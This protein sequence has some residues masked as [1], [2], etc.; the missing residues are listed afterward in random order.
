MNFK[1][2]KNFLY[3]FLV[4]FLLFFFLF[5]YIKSSN[6]IQYI[7]YPFALILSND[8]IFII[9]QNGV[10]I[11]DST[12]SNLISDEIVFSETEK[13]TSKQSL[14]KVTISQF[15]N[16]YIISLINDKIYFFD[17]KGNFFFNSIN[18]VIDIYA[19][20]YYYTLVPIKFYK[21][22]FFYIIGYVVDGGLYFKYYKFHSINKQN[23]LINSY[24]INQEGDTYTY[25]IREYGLS[26]EFMSYNFNDKY[27]SCFL[28]KTTEPNTLFIYNY[29]VNETDIQYIGQSNSGINVSNI[30]C[31]KSVINY[32]GSKSFICF[33]D[34]QKTCYCFK[35]DIND[36]EDQGSKITLK[37]LFQNQCNIEY[38]SMKVGYIQG[39]EE[40][41]ISSLS[42]DNQLFTC[43]YNESL[44]LTLN[45]NKFINCSNIGGYSI[46]YSYKTN[47][48][49]DL[50]DV[51]CYGKRYPFN[52]LNKEIETTN[53]EISTNPTTIIETIETTIQ[54]NPIT[55]I[56]T[57]Y[58]I[59]TTVPIL[60]SK[61]SIIEN[62]ESTSIET[63]TKIMKMKKMNVMN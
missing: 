60:S 37:I 54:T 34:D 32:A 44:A 56:E 45:I 15:E 29:S 58:L 8:N 6:S 50:S 18:P 17:Y 13:L 51:E 24:I 30:K 1:K 38:Y 22:H 42:I 7:N 61:T 36:I 35:Y 39:K 25:Q 46:L 62:E 33:Y 10:S 16:G 49:Y 20:G 2:N 23:I 48:Y 31:I 52:I 11:Y 5:K 21:D 14:S 28:V 40:F 4:F 3:N 26:C 9:H 55:L 63:E 41:I 47:E 27:L 12:F 53:E 43:I 59:E 57:S 19:P